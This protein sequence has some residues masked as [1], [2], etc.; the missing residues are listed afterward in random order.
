MLSIPHVYLIL[1]IKIKRSDIVGV[2][3]A[4]LVGALE[5]LTSKQFKKKM[6]GRIKY[7]Q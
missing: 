4:N 1:K 2:C 7:L 3:F 6:K 5:S